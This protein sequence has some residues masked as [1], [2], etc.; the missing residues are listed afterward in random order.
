MAGGWE[1]PLCR[2]CSYITVD[3]ATPAPW[4]GVSHFGVLFNRPRCLMLPSLNVRKT[5]QLW[6]K[7]LYSHK[8]CQR[9]GKKPKNLSKNWKGVGHQWWGDAYSLV[10]IQ[11]GANL[12]ETC[13]ECPMKMYTCNAH[14][15]GDYETSSVNH[16]IQYF[17]SSLIYFPGPIL[18]DFIKLTI[19]VKLIFVRV[20][21]K[22][23]FV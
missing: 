18:W 11:N 14:F 2:E 22:G 6:S 21:G 4:N 13:I 9:T 15:G 1:V 3:T 8:P 7:W 12:N 23:G 5:K 16:I 10:F 20:E 17:F 19:K